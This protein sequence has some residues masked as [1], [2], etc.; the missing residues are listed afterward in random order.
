MTSATSGIFR[1]GTG[2]AMTEVG[3]EVEKAERAGG[4]IGRRTVQV[5][6]R[7]NHSVGQIHLP[8]SLTRGAKM[9]I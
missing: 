8:A 7:K 2:S 4:E 5:E 3:G 6:K 9:Q 1:F